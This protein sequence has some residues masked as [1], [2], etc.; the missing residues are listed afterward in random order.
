MSTLDSSN[1]VSHR[2][3][4]PCRVERNISV[5]GRALILGSGVPSPRRITLNRSGGRRLTTSFTVRFCAFVFDASANEGVNTV[6][7]K[8]TVLSPGCH[9]K[10][11]QNPKHIIHVAYPPCKTAAK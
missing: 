3:V 9:S 1:L 2:G 11:T 8:I 4:L 10:Y 5:F 7:I 6:S